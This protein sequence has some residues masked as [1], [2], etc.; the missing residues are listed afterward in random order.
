MY[1]MVSQAILEYFREEHGSEVLD[2]VRTQAGCEGV[3]FARMT[4][5]P[6]EIS[7]QLIVA[8]AEILDQPAAALLEKVGEY[9]VDFA[10]RSDYGELLRI[11][12]RT[13][14]E[15][16]QNLDQLH[17]RVGEAFPNLEP[18]SFWCD[19]VGDDSLVLHYASDRAGLEPMVIGIVNG[20]GRML[21][22]ET[23]VAPIATEPA[24][25]SRF[26]VNFAAGSLTR[27]VPTPRPASSEHSGAG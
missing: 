5:Y 6:D 26:R 24:S 27:N 20:L 14:P 1:G 15:V 4:Q 11:A 7:V 8:A 21:G 19:E 9:W 18:P 25:P 3:E 10:L 16:L 13:L 12:G 17:T 2:A 23:K 22:V